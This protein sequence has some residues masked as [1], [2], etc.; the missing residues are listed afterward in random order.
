MPGDELINSFREEM[1]AAERYG[2]GTLNYSPEAV[3]ARFRAE[4]AR[5]AAEAERAAYEQVFTESIEK[6][7]RVRR[8]AAEAATAVLE[9]FGIDR[10]V[11][12]RLAGA[13][14]T[15]AAILSD[16]TRRDVQNN[17]F[18]VGVGATIGDAAATMYAA[19]RLAA[20]FMPNVAT[21]VAPTLGRQMAATGAGFG[22]QMGL[23]DVGQRLTGAAATGQPIDGAELVTEGAKSTVIG[24]VTGASFPAISRAGRA[25]GGRAMGIREGVRPTVGQ[26]VGRRAIEEAAFFGSADFL[27]TPGD[28]QQ[29]GIAALQGIIASPVLGA[30][31]I[32]HDFTARLGEMT[33]KEN[34]RAAVTL[35]DTYLKEMPLAEVERYFKTTPGWPGGIRDYA[36][37]HIQGNRKILEAREWKPETVA[38]ARDVHDG[39]AAKPDARALRSVLGRSLGPNAAALPADFGAWADRKIPAFILPDPTGTVLTPK[40]RAAAP[41]LTALRMDELRKAGANAIKTSR[42]TLF[43]WPDLAQQALT[44]PGGTRAV[45]EQALSERRGAPTTV[46]GAKFTPRGLVGSLRLLADR[47]AIGEVLGYGPGNASKDAATVLMV[48]YDA[49][50]F[51]VRSIAT[52]PERIESTRA[53]LIA[54]GASKDGIGIYD[55]SAADAIVGR[56]LKT[57]WS[58]EGPK[59]DGELPKPRR[60]VAPPSSQPKLLGMETTTPEQPEAYFATPGGKLI[61][62]SKIEEMFA[63]NGDHPVEI[64]RQDLGEFTQRQDALERLGREMESGKGDGLYVAPVRVGKDVRWAIV[65]TEQPTG[66][67]RPTEQRPIELPEDPNSPFAPQDPFPVIPPEGMRSMTL[68]GPRPSPLQPMTPSEA[69]EVEAVDRVA[70]Q[71]RQ[72]A[73]AAPIGPETYGLEPRVG[74]SRPALQERPP[75]VE[76][77]R[78]PPREASV[79][80]ALDFEAPAKDG[81]RDPLDVGDTAGDPAR[82]QIGSPQVIFTRDNDVL[83][84]HYALVPFADLRMSH[85]NRNRPIEGYPQRLQNRAV[86]GNEESTKKVAGII[87]SFRDESP[88]V[89]LAL[90]A[91]RSSGPPIVW[92]DTKGEVGVAGKAY[93]LAGN[94]RLRAIEKLRRDG[95]NLYDTTLNDIADRVGLN[96][97]GVKDAVLVRV[98]RDMPY[99]VAKRYVEPLQGEGSRERTEFERSIGEAQA[100]GV[101][102]AADIRL[103]WVPEGKLEPSDVVPFL[104]KNRDLALRLY[105]RGLEGTTSTAAAKRINDV[106][107]G[108]LPRDLLNA[109]SR[110]GEEAEKAVYEIAP[111]LHLFNTLAKAGK[112]KPEWDITPLIGPALKLMPEFAKHVGA[113][114][115]ALNEWAQEIATKPLGFAAEDDILRVLPTSPE[116]IEKLRD[117]IGIG[118]GFATGDRA[119]GYFA[120]KLREYT[121]RALADNDSRQGKMFAT[122]AQKADGS[123]DVVAELFTKSHAQSVDKLVA[124]MK[125]AR[126]LGSPQIGESDGRPAEETPRANE[127]GGDRPPRSDARRS[128]SSSGGAGG[129]GGTRSSGERAVG[130]EPRERRGD[131]GG[132]DPREPAAE[133]PRRVSAPIASS[134]RRIVETFARSGAVDESAIAP[135]IAKHLSPHQAKGVALALEKLGPDKPHSDRGFIIAD[136]TGVGKTREI[137]SLAETFR[138]RNKGVLIVAPAE[139][140]KRDAKDNIRGSYAD[141]GATMGVSFRFGKGD[142]PKRGEIV[143]TTYNSDWIASVKP[144]DDLV[145]MLDESHSL[146]NQDSGRTMSIGP[147]IEKAH[148]VV[149]ASAT[150]GDKP[151]HMPYLVRAGVLEGRSMAQQLEQLGYR[152]TVRNL[153]K[154]DGTIEE[155]E[156]WAPYLKYG[157]RRK[158]LFALSQRLADNGFMV[159]REISMQGVD[160]DV[161]KVEYGADAREIEAKLGVAFGE[162]EGRALLRF[163]RQ[164]E[165][166]KVKAAVEE[167][168]KEIGQGR[169]VVIF[170]NRVNY[171]A[172]KRKIKN[173]YGEVVAEEI[174]AESDGTLRTLKAALIAAGLKE[175]EIAEIHGGA[176]REPGEEMGRFQR[177]EARVVIA[178]PES[179]GTGISLD[180]RSGTRPRTMIFLTAPMSGTANAQAWGRVWRLPTKGDARIRYLIGES[181]AEQR[182]AGIVLQKAAVLGGTLK[183]EHMRLVD[184]A[185]GMADADISEVL[186]DMDAGEKVGKAPRSLP[187]LKTNYLAVAGLIR[188]AWSTT[189]ARETWSVSVESDRARAAIIEDLR[190]VGIEAKIEGKNVT[191]KKLV[192]AA[193]AR[194][195]RDVREWVDAVRDNPKLREFV[196]TLP[197]EKAQTRYEVEDAM[198]LLAG[199]RR[200]TGNRD[201]LRQL[202]E[203]LGR[204]QAQLVKMDAEG[205]RPC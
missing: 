169:S 11:L 154:K 19:G 124:A 13:D 61:P 115:R 146:K 32:H 21:R 53:A 54:S 9:A 163:L 56:R 171:S 42:G 8:G 84:S 110:A 201:A 31:D 82:I 151:E 89:L 184:L 77:P 28:L 122:T 107:L 179:G 40:E 203:V 191:G 103:E 102:R 60:W 118:T 165:P 142:T 51:E 176:E 98:L 5:R 137:L 185:A 182:L 106:L 73:G 67:I 91:D 177:N 90:Q 45:L 160:V 18:T 92:V 81:P 202:D 30:A 175:N 143:V 141:D 97:S 34:A 87:A 128:G 25:V 3:H 150:W 192:V 12:Y 88:S 105:P 4:R 38:T 178:T 65:K 35:V 76:Q 111:A 130:S 2:Y 37:R 78:L 29:R 23:R 63:A 33:P 123:V 20:P 49:Q 174:I 46:D 158:R 156:V 71:R 187:S 126:A 83:R 155:R 148:A 127:G 74:E 113:G 58:P 24:A 198:E 152:K 197:V 193:E 26:T 129:S 140:L 188:N 136:G 72:R 204:L 183:G 96:T 1:A 133:Q 66:G 186:A 47:D 64:V 17:P 121:A 153:K 43:F 62:A 190:R 166:H 15:Q 68:E 108:A 114:K 144:S 39:V 6:Q 131:G 138:R 70:Q 134:E 69:Q 199:W 164:L 162:P 50:G 196:D 14:P 22:A 157:E 59:F 41:A 139:V 116:M 125:K 95:E 94:H 181:R 180:D 135:D 10:S 173:A 159:K 168:M 120:R 100:A 79:V 57:S 80:S 7:S 27:M 16:T 104:E 93:V 52:S 117:V 85:D 167:T 200:S 112:I 205:R 145:V 109:V 119:T 75:A 132:R 161:R 55:I 195:Y 44:A 170:A 189:K 172:E 194:D 147:L 86:T 36:L 48:G 99:D 149:Y 101:D